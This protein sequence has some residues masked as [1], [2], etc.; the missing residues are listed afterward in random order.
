[1]SRAPR[2]KGAT[3]SRSKAAADDGERYPL[4]VPAPILAHHL[5]T[6]E[7]SMEQWRDQR[8]FPPVL[9]LTGPSGVGKRD[10]SYFLAQW[11]NCEHAGFTHRSGSEGEPNQ[12][13]EL[14]FG[15]DLGPSIP[16]A[17]SIKPPESEEPL[18]LAP[19]GLC[20]HCQR[21]L[22]GTWVDFTEIS[23][24]AGEGEPGTL[25]IDQFRALRDSQGRGAFDGNFRI[26]L[27]RDADHMTN[28]AANSLLKLLE[29]PPPNW[30]FLLTAADPS[31]LLPTLVSR[32]QLLRLRPIPEAAL[33]EV[34]E[35]S[36]VPAGRR[37]ECAR[38]A[39]GS[40]GKAIELGTDET[41][42]RRET[43]FRFLENPKAEWGTLVDWSAQSANSA[44][45]LLEQ[46]EQA[47]TELLIA[48]IDAQP[49]W[50]SQDGARSLQKHRDLLVK[51][52]GSLPAAR[53]FWIARAE[54]V[55]RTRQALLAPL[56]KKILM[57]DLLLPWL[58]G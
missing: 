42:E 18:A 35:E 21:A 7:R 55:F 32:C 33:T 48:S 37:A 49:A 9:L 8:R 4:P 53:E 15:F 23:A 57:Q 31:L 24:D 22:H 44:G 43:V 46:L 45:F 50:T 11:L 10:I 26:T 5:Q 1:M 12:G 25:K 54:Q 13:E 28:Q 52:T 29:E 40:W 39:Q 20:E 17:T 47:L 6:L 34:L 19:C 27:I 2:A 3:G 58:A 30:V 38:L 56:N 16:A 41:W 36:P 51:Q 14:G